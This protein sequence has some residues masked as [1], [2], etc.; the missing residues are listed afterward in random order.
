MIVRI[1]P[2]QIN[3]VWDIIKYGCI[4]ANNVRADSVYSFTNNLL[5][6]LL[7]GRAQAWINYEVVDE[8]RDINAIAVTCF[9]HDPI[10][11]VDYLLAHSVYGYKPMK[12]EW[13]KES[14]EAMCAFSKANNCFKFVA[15]TTDERLTNV[16]KRIGLEPELY[17]YSKNI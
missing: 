6:M 12:L 4:Q 3:E 17:V 13:L 15:M 1:Q 7:S 14:V 8:K 5:E 2:E 16:Y 11:N 10:F 9:M